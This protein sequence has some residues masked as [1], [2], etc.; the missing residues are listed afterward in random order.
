MTY[1]VASGAPS[2]TIG[3]PGAQS[4]P[5]FYGAS[6]GQGGVGPSPLHV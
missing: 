5:D 3:G 2:A 1:N 4:M 6:A